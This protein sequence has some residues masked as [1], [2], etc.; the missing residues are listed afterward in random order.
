MP[1]TPVLVECYAGS[2]AFERPRRILI[3]GLSHEVIRAA[4]LSVEE[5]AASRLLRHRFEVLIQDGR[6]FVLIRQG[7]Q[8]FL[9]T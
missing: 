9:E 6:R 4:P 8:W 2:K 3:D 1:L 5:D 7:D